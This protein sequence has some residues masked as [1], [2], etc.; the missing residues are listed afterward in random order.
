[1]L[2]ELIALKR[3]D[4]YKGFD[5]WEDA[6]R[7]SCRTLL[8]DGSI[9]QEYVDAIVDNIKEHGPYI[10]ITENLAIPH[11]K[12]NAGG[13]NANA[14][15]FTKLEKAVSFD[16]NDPEKDACLFFTLAAK[17]IDEHYKN[18]EK[19]SELLL[20]GSIMKELLEVNDIA[21]L[22]VLAAKYGV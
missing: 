4:F 10:V 14:I 1:M 3:V 9:T 22:E 15:S 7:A 19:L 13:V 11:T 12:V 17:D 6:V 21:A 20:S 5:N 16:P 18:M 8:A 2:S